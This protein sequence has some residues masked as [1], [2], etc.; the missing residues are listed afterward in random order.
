MLLA[1]MMSLVQVKE[2]EDGLA[3][4]QQSSAHLQS[5]LDA[6]STS[7]QSQAAE[8]TSARAEV[9]RLTAERESL[10]SQLTEAQ[11]AQQAAR[12]TAATHATAAAD[13]Q[14]QWAAKVHARPACSLF[15]CKHIC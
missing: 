5:Q 14:Q 6:A 11:R 10:Q 4:A 2:L 9:A 12:E 3:A 8:V 15:W 1:Y 7:A 13:E